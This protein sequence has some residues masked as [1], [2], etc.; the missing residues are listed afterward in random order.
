MPSHLVREVV[1]IGGTCVT[2]SMAMANLSSV[3]TEGSLGEGVTL[4]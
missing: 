3:G 4:Q 2:L 1:R